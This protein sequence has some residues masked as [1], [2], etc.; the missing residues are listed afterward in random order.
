[1]KSW[2]D[3]L[4]KEFNPKGMT[5]TTGPDEPGVVNNHKTQCDNSKYIYCLAF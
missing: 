4:A 1:M 3:V 5:I 2:R